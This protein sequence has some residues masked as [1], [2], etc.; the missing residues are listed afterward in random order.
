M[1]AVV[2]ETVRVPV[3]ITG[4]YAD[5]GCKDITMDTEIGT[6]MRLKGDCDT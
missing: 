4:T 1:I 5:E 3:G 2:P 6:Y